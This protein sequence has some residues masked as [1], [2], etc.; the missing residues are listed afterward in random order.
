[1]NCHFGYFKLTVQKSNDLILLCLRGKDRRERVR[2]VCSQ[3]TAEWSSS[4]YLGYF[5]MRETSAPQCSWQ[6]QLRYFKFFCFLIKKTKRT[7]KLKP[8]QSSACTR[9]SSEAG[10][11]DNMSDKKAEKAAWCNRTD[12]L[13]FMRLI[14][15]ISEKRKKKRT[16]CI[17]QASWTCARCW[18]KSAPVDERR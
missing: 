17:V 4:G 8:L 7:D 9:P 6:V 2:E 12:T 18:C 3:V 1:M 10:R 5:N 13:F 16:F 15:S 14:M 11:Q